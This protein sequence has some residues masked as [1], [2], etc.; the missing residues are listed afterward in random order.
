MTLRELVDVIAELMMAHGGN[1]EVVTEDGELVV[2]A[3][4]NVDEEPCILLLL[5]ETYGA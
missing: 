5:K 3:E 1:L 2:G 4:F